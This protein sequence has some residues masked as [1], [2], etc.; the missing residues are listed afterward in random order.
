MTSLGFSRA[1]L[2]NSVCCQPCRCNSV[3]YKK[4]ELPAGPRSHGSSADLGWAPTGSTQSGAQVSST[5]VLPG[6]IRRGT[7]F[8]W[9]TPESKG[10]MTCGGTLNVFAPVTSTDM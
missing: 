10:R 3:V 8:S 7:L 4:H 9:L 5:R 2:T 1:E 6:L